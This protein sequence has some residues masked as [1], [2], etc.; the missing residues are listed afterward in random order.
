MTERLYY[1]Q[2][3]LREF[4]AR[5]LEKRTENGQTL[6]RLDR[7]AFYPTSGGQPFDTGTLGVFRVTDV[8]VD[9]AGE[10]WHKVEGDGLCEGD[11]VHGVIDWNRRFDH[12]QQHAGEHLLAGMV[13]RQLAGTTIGLHLGV[14]FSTIDVTLPDGRTHL[15]GEEIASLEEEVNRHI[16]EDLPIRCWFPDAEELA[17]LPLRKTPTVK[18]HVRIVAMGDVEMVACGGTHPSS[19][20]Q[21]GLVKVIDARPARGKLRL[22]FVCGMRA[23]RLFQQTFRAAQGA[24]AL[25]SAKAEELPEAVERVKEHAALQARELSQLKKQQA[26]AQIE[27]MLSG[28]KRLPSGARLV[29]RHLGEAT[30]ETLKETASALIEH[31]GVYVLLSAGSLLLFAR[32]ADCSADMGKLLRESGARGGGRPEFAQGSAPDAQAVFA[33][34]EA[35][36]DQ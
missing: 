14:D 17:A 6:L 8:F 27:G 3:Y 22:A 9:D 32:S 30:P 23:V 15:T 26:L 12:M 28:A 29:A 7:S 25:L 19:T 11:A 10:V 20:G 1:D 18:E 24:A 16:Q 5:I 2:T 13:Y 36:L 34:A 33:K 31:E 21:I 35:L 4:D